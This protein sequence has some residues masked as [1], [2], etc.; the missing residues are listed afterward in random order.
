MVQAVMKRQYLSV[1]PVSMSNC[2]GLKLR[3]LA[4][5]TEKERS[6]LGRYLFTSPNFQRRASLPKL[7]IY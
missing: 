4:A 7:K 6:S 1:A 3:G 5:K 2:G